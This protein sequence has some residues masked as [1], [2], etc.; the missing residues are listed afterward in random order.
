MEN[1]EE[2]AIELDG[3]TLLELSLSNLRNN[4][5]RDFGN[6]RETKANSISI[7]N[8]DMIPSVGEKT[9]LIKARVRGQEGKN[10]QSQVRFVNVGFTTEAQPGFTQIK[11]VD[12]QDYYVKQF[13]ASQTQAKVKCNCLDFYWRFAVWNHAKKSLEGDPPPPYVKKTDSPPVNPNKTPG[14]CKHIIKLISFLRTEQI[15]R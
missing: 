2:Q 7:S 10:Y 4:V 9:L 13:T 8:Y 14:S 12:G 6:T 5:K 3:E 1:L 11:A 15:L